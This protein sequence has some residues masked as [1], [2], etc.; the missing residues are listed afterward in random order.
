MSE[1]EVT[2]L[3]FLMRQTIFLESEIRE[4]VRNYRRKTDMKRQNYV[5]AAQVA[6]SICHRLLCLGEFHTEY[7]QGKLDEEVKFL[8]K[9]LEKKEN[10][11]EQKTANS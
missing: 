4:E 1:R 3:G 6:A 7:V 2:A 8:K 9:Y 5:E 11:N 10:G